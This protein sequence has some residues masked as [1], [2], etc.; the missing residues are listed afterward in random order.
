MNEDER[1][2]RERELERGNK[3]KAILESDLFNES[4]D[5]LKA[6]YIR[7]WENSKLSE[8]PRRELLYNMVANLSDVKLHFQTVL[9]TGKLASHQLEHI[10][11]E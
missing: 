2:L 9:E 3:A 10:N 4:F 8:G 11:E 1:F 5:L 6:D 7:E